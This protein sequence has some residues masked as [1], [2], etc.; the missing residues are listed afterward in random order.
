MGD[1]TRRLLVIGIGAGDPSFLTRQAIDAIGR[2]DVFVVL[3][4]GEV[5]ADLVGLRRD[6]LDTYAPACRTIDIVDS[7]R[8]PERSYT[9]AVEVWHGERVERVEQALLDD[10]GPDD[11]AG[12]LVWGDPSLYDSTL[13]I[14]DQVIARGR[15]AV[16]HEV[17]PGISSVQVLAARHRVALNRIGR[18]I[19]ITTGRQLRETDPAEVDDVVVMLDGETS[20]T[21]L[22]GHGFEIFWGAYLGTDDEILVAGRLD[23]VAADIVA[24]RVEARARKGWVF[25][26]YLLRRPASD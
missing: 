12:I 25:D 3:D 7:R 23:D 24:A 14:I 26:I 8:D 16:D 17:I 4:K 11:C 6:I 21:G 13:R 18:P 15:V 1:V 19:T 20:F 9:D 22:V 10:V 2:V 5:A